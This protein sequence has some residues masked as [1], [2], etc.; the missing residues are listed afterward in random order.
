MNNITP[1]KNLNKRAAK[2]KLK[3]MLGGYIDFCMYLMLSIS[4]FRNW[5]EKYEL[6]KMLVSLTMLTIFLLKCGTKIFK[7]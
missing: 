2:T 6:K 1:C 7:Q 5:N 4:C 3:R